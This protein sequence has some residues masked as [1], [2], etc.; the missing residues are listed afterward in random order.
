MDGIFIKKKTEII[1]MTLA[2]AA[3]AV[4]ILIAVYALLFDKDASE[5]FIWFAKM[6][7]ILGLV[8][9]LINGILLYLKKR[10]FIHVS[11]EGIRAFSLNGA[12]LECGYNDFDRVDWIGP[13]L[14]VWMKN[15]KKYSWIDLEN[16]EELSRY[17]RKRLVPEN[18]ASP[19]IDEMV[20][21]VKML[22]GK[23]DRGRRSTF[24]WLIIT[25]SLV[26]LWIILMN[27]KDTVAIVPLLLAAAAGA[28]F[29][30]FCVIFVRANE[31]LHEKDKRLKQKILA[32]D[33]IRSGKVLDHYIDEDISGPFR[34][35]VYGFSD[36]EDVF[37]VVE[38]VNS[39]Y[40]VERVFESS[41]FSDYSSLP[42]VILQH[43]EE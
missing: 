14:T 26:I 31:D 2:A 41:V 39:Q 24:L 12:Y 20:A 18:D 7:L 30:I 8:A 23:R 25:V 10:S 19:G 36:S 9:F 37:Y 28:V 22:K 43:E 17:I 33:P 6:I 16:S 29:I 35:V 32:G 42:D 34:V 21:E 13:G 4:S 3:G 15:G 27:V 1:G 5:D 40:E 38:N 11:E